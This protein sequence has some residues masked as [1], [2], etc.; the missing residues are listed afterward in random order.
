[1]TVNLSYLRY[2]ESKQKGL[3]TWLLQQ[4]STVKL[5]P[6]KLLALA[7]GLN[8]CQITL[9]M[10]FEAVRLEENGK[11]KYELLNSYQVTVTNIEGK[12]FFYAEE[13]EVEEL[14]EMGYQT[15]DG[16]KALK[17]A[18]KAA[19]SFCESFRETFEEAEAENT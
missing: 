14:I 5:K 11:V 19:E 17:D 3:L 2:I 1:M 12:W 9:L 6:F 4:L 16:F 10:L 7:T 13:H 15:K 8:S 18:K